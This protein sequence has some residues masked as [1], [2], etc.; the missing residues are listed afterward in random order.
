MAELDSRVFMELVNT[1]INPVNASMARHSEA[2]TSI[3]AA[4]QRIAEIVQTEPTRRTLLD[5]IREDLARLGE[6]YAHALKEHDRMCER[7]GGDWNTEDVRRAGE[8]VRCAQDAL[9]EHMGKHEEHTDGKLKPVDDMKKRFDELLWTIRIAVGVGISAFGY[10]AWT[11]A[12]LPVP[13]KP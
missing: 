8:I 3:L 2:M 1:I 12:H 7:R 9:K 10:L 6:E 11:L 5:E 13:G 4:V